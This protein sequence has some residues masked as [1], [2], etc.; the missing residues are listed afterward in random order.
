MST[1][2]THLQ[3]TESIPV[4]CI[5]ID[6]AATKPKQDDDETDCEAEPELTS[7][8]LKYNGILLNY[9]KGS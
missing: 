9:R 7:Q 8:H 2:K 1:R 4:Y 6:L 5:V 3:L